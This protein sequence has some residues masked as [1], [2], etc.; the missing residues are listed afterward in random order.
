MS[1]SPYGLAFPGIAPLFYLD[2]VITRDDDWHDLLPQFL[3]GGQPFDISSMSI[4]MW[5][6]P[7]F[8]FP[9][10]PMLHLQNVAAPAEGIRYD[11]APDAL[12]TIHVSRATVIANLPIGTWTQFAVLSDPASTYGWTT[13]EV[14]RGS[15]VVQP[16]RIG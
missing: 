7:A 9:G 8:D 4:D 5:V 12:M 10:A 1:D 3:I 11:S 16:G 2:F 6:R 15:L 13:R 14:W